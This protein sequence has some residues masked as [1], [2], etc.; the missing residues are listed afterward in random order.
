MSYK[1]R[2]FYAVQFLVQCETRKQG[3]RFEALHAGECVVIFCVNIFV[4]E[5]G[6]SGF[7]RDFVSHLLDCAV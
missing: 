4:P 3:V 6:G 2:C 1:A 5:N 7:L